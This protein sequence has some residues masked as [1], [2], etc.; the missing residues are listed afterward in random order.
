MAYSPTNS[1]G[2]S[3]VAKLRS[4][5]RFAKE[6]VMDRVVKT[7]WTHANIDTTDH[8]FGVIPGTAHPTMTELN[9]SGLMAA[10]LNADS[11]GY[12]FLWT[13][14][15]EIDLAQVVRFR[16]GFSNSEAVNTALTAAWT[17]T[18]DALVPGTTAVN[19]ASTALTATSTTAALGA[20]VFQRSNWGTMAAATL[21][22]ATYVPGDAIMN[23]KVTVDVT[24]MA[25]ASLLTGQV[26]YYRRLIG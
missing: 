2:I 9:S 8:L 3:T 5:C 18:Y 10:L 24:T 4:S 17:F 16:V 7:L 11:E 6:H 13:I 22:A 23:W 19:V 15:Q 12:S 20:N 1:T 21:D 25:D 14:P 26:Q